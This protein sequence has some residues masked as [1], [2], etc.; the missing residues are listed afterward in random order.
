[1]RDWRRSS[2]QRM[3][4]AAVSRGQSRRGGPAGGGRPAD[5]EE[6]GGAGCRASAV[7]DEHPSRKAR[8][9]ARARAGSSL[10]RPGERGSQRAPTAC[11]KRRD[12][13]APRAR[14]ATTD[15]PGVSSRG[16][17]R[18]AP[19]KRPGLHRR[20][21]VA[22][23]GRCCATGRRCGSLA[24]G[25]GQHE[26]APNWRVLALS[27][28]LRLDNPARDETGARPAPVRGTRQSERHRGEHRRS[29]AFGSKTWRHTDATCHHAIEGTD[30]SV[31]GLPLS[32]ST[33][34]P[35]GACGAS[36]RR[37]SSSPSC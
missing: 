37:V 25:D 10:A 33:S 19:M 32:A 7:A 6:P 30:G 5:T 27:E 29:L 26:V 14:L 34:P 20:G 36:P 1:M 9:P 13:R 31:K 2:P 15:P 17:R 12:R 21:R 3:V 22:R 24:A 4:T 35:A 23:P 8:A 16:P 18:P 11:G 28:E